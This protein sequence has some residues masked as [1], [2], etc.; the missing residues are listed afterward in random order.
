MKIRA[1]IPLVFLLSSGAF[2]QS[3]P[4]SGRSMGTEMAAIS[5]EVFSDFQCP[6]CKILY[7]KTLVPLIQDYVKTGRVHLIER[8]FPLPQHAY[9]KPAACYAC[10]ADRIGKYEQVCDVLFRKQD[11]WSVTGKVDETVCSVLTPAEAAKVRA[12][13]KDP[14][15]MAEVERDMNLG[16]RLGIHATPTMIIAHSGQSN[17]VSGAVSYP[18]L[19][20][21]L[22]Q[23]AAK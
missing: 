13:A 12:L 5:I 20:R 2:G 21:Y 11:S 15:I 6:T 10:A 14:A 19:R 23:L 18:I 7:E 4:A 22:D 17:P 1:A 3:Q 8:T 16:M 9:A